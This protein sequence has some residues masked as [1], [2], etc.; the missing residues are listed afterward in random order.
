MQFTKSASIAGGSS[1]RATWALALTSVAFFMTA[2]DALVVITA[3]PAI[4][5]SL[6]GTDAT[7]EWTINAYTLTLAAGIITAAALGDRLGR[8]RMYV[9]GLLAFTVASA[10]CALAPTTGLLIAARAVQ[11]LGAALITPLSL[12]ILAAA[13]PAERRASTVG[14]WGA[15]GGLAVAG[16]PLIGGAV[17]QGLDWHWI[18]WL[19]VPVGLVAAALSVT[20]L[21]EA[22]GPRAR[23][24][25]PAVVLAAG[26]AVALAWGLVRSADIG[27]GSPQVLGALSLAAALIAGFIAWERRAGEPMLPLRMLRVPAFAAANATGFAMM[28]SITSAAFLMSQY[29]QLGLGHSPLSTGL[30]FLPWTLTPLLIAPAA[31]ALAD[32][33]GP[34]PLMAL[35]LAMQAAGLGW[36]ALT[37]TGTTG[38]RQFVPALVLAGVGIS[39]AIP[40][41]PAAALNAVRSAD[42]GKASGVQSTLQRFGAV[43][44]VAI[45][46]AVFSSNGDLSTPAGVVAGFRPALAAAAGFSLAGALAALATAGRRRPAPAEPQPVRVL[47]TTGR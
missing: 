29:F 25:L 37:A 20:K 22:Y 14:I 28:A 39:M 27:W 47:A 19:N 7:L 38:Y 44:G 12:T 42:I 13:F 43:F 36:I 33:I 2:L 46:V 26:G 31:G 35:G 23:L 41:V 8:R 18:F 3:L 32:R 1:P 16:G 34:R 10:A 11:G 21:P 17:V 4:H 24:D 9:A 6:G 15:I 5:A 30:R 45:V 40:T